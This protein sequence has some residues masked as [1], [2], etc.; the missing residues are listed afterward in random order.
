MNIDVRAQYVIHLKPEE[1]I[2]NDFLNIRTILNQPPYASGSLG[3]HTTLLGFFSDYSRLNLDS[4]DSLDKR[5]VSALNKLSTNAMQGK[6]LTYADYDSHLVVLVA[7]DSLCE[8]HLDAARLFKPHIVLKGGRLAKENAIWFRDRYKHCLENYSPHISVCN[9][10]ERIF[11]ESALHKLDGQKFN[12]VELALS[13]KKG[14]RWEKLSTI[15]LN[16]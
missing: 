7:N 1:K 5:L 15:S 12:Y 6:F 4:Q 13:K 9:F 16:L 2:V 3:V 11:D 8:M 10:P 14:N